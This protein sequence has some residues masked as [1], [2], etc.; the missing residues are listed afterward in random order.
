M[1]PK[2]FQNNID[3]GLHHQYMYNTLQINRG[4]KNDSLPTFSNIATYSGV[5]ST[6]WSWGIL[7]ADFNNNGLKDIIVSNGIKRDI[8]NNDFFNQFKDKNSTYFKNPK[9]GNKPTLKDLKDIPSEPLK[10]YIFKNNGD[11]TFTNKSDDWGLHHKTFSNGLAYADFDNDGDLDLVINNIDEE[12]GFYEN[13]SNT[14]ENA[15]YLK[16]NFKGTKQNKLGIGNTV[17][18]YKDGKLQLAE[19]MLT[20]GYQSSVAP[21]LHFGVGDIKTLD[22][23]VVQW[24]DGSTQI[25]N[26]IKTNQLVTLNYKNSEKNTFRNPFLKQSKLF[27]DITASTKI[28]FK[29]KENK[30]FDYNKEPLL[31]HKMSQFGPG[32]AV[33][34]LNGDGLDD[35]WVGGAYRQSG[36][37]YLQQK[38]GTFKTSNNELFNNDKNQ[39]D[40]DGVLFDVDNDGDLDLY[41][42]SGGNEFTPNSKEYKDRLYINDGKGNFIK[43]KTALPEFSESGSKAIPIDFDQDGD[44]DLFVTSRL[45]PQFYPKPP[46]S[47]LLE[48]VSSKNEVKFIESKINS[49]TVFHKLGLVTDAISIDFDN[50]NDEDLIVVGEW[51]PIT[52]LENN[53]GKFTNITNK[54]LLKNTNGWW[55]SIHKT[56]L[57]KDGDLDFIVGNLGLNYKYKASPEKTFDVYANDFDNNKKLD[58]VLGYYEG[59]TQYPVRGRQCSSQQVPG[60]KNKF[61]NYEDFANADLEDIYT[62]KKLKSGIHYKAETFA[63][64]YIEN[65]G[66]ATFKTHQLPKEAQFSSINTILTDDYDLDGEKDILIAGNLYASE[67]ET[68]RNDASIGLLMKQTDNGLE[69][70]TFNKSGFLADKDVKN[71]KTITIQGKK[72]ILIA[73]NDAGLQ[74]FQVN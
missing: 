32:I 55:Y 68:P 5:K 31:P 9:K 51:M 1:S 57:D 22:S 36:A 10:N 62:T 27:K 21:E 8:N 69:S 2:E 25:L 53:N 63:S 45:L 48:N 74:I 12:A 35:F 54:N 44:M 59:K 41:V 19:L 49:D 29:H 3:L 7:F 34:D 33:G 50:D 58:I 46:N 43:N 17:K 67:A 64:V 23:L 47:H 11:L 39:E 20:R 15:N 70:V 56:D 24:K 13:T 38:N 52:F 26:N 16:I 40:L 42:V 30:Y 61:K 73:N 14:K 4:F 71:M 28:D 65:L 6:D 18:I 66:N 37:I 60:I 72:C